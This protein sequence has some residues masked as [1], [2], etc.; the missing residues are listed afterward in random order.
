MTI[1]EAKEKVIAAAEAEVGYHEK[2]SKKDLD[3]KKGNAGNKNYTKFA[4][5]FDTKAKD[6]YNG[7]KDPCAWCDVFYD[8]LFCECFGEAKAREMLFQPKRSLGAGCKYSAGYYRAAKQFFAAPAVGDQIFFGTKGAETHTGLVVKVTDKMVYTI[9]GNASNEVRKKNYQ[10]SN[11]KISGYG[12]PKWSVVAS[13]DKPA[14][15]EKP[16]SDN[17]STAEPTKPTDGTSGAN[18]GGSLKAFQVIAVH[19]LNLRKTMVIPAK[20]SEN[21]VTVLPY[22]AQVTSDGSVKTGGGEKW[23][24]VKY[25]NKA[26]EVYEGYCCAKYLKAI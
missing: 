12:R 20:S 22:E 17:S 18:S 21:L 2:A 6:F 24:R 15:S 9:E 4:E 7:K 19:G 3:S 5:W 8:Y 23:L 14:A 1:Q 16:V 13:A 10:R 25:K 26:G 11:K